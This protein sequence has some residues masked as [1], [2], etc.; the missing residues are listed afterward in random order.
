MDLSLLVDGP[1]PGGRVRS[2]SFP[3]G[4]REMGM[5]DIFKSKIG[6]LKSCKDVDGLIIEPIRR[7]CKPPI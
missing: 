5:T 6:R 4:D 2:S 1:N 3:K 7:Y